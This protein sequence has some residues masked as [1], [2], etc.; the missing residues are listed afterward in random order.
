MS[1]NQIIRYIRERKA[2]ERLWDSMSK[3]QRRQVLAEADNDT[4][5]INEILENVKADAEAGAAQ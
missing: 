3:K 1:D 5:L 4:W 2:L